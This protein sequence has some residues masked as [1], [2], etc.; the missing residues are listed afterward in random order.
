MKADKWMMAA[1]AVGL[2]MAGTARAG[3]LAPPGAP[4]PTMKSLQEI[5]DK[6]GDLETTV[7]TQQTQIT[8]LQTQNAALLQQSALMLLNAGVALLWSIA[9]VDSEGSVGG[10][11][12]L[13]FGPDGQPAIA[14]YDETNCDLKFAR[15]GLFT[16]R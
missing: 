8:T 14:Y 1:V 11:A 2:V 15:M 13:A 6:I 3:S 16:P 9:T 10:Y 5:W 12:S 7:G 4:E